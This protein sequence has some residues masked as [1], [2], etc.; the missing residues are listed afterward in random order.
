M[1]WPATL[2]TVFGTT[3]F[4]AF[5]SN[6]KTITKAPTETV[7]YSLHDQARSYFKEDFNFFRGT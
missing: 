1:S 6:T 4:K 7:Y 5:V 3:N 2:S